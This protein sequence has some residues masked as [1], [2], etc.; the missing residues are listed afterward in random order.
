MQIRRDKIPINSAKDFEVIAERLLF[1]LFDTSTTSQIIE[2]ACKVVLFL[3]AADSFSF[4]I[5]TEVYRMR[6]LRIVG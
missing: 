6:F 2:S 4:A 3:I 1:N 5:V